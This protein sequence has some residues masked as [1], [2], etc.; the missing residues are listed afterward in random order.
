[1]DDKSLLDVLLG[2]DLPDMRV[3]MPTKE[4]EVSRLSDL[5]GEPVVFTVKA[6]SY[7]T[8]TELREVNSGSI[9]I[10]VLLAGVVSPDFTSPHLLK[11]FGAV[12]SEGVVKAMLLAGE[13]A[14]LSRAIEELSGYRRLTVNEVK[15]G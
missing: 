8:I 15:N 7:D 13:I 11:H 6:L 2:A 14:D 12:D 5:T 1:M 3:A 4:L 10:P 9:T